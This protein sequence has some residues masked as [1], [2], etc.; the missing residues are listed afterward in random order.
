MKKVLEVILALILSLGLPAS[1]AAASPDHTQQVRLYGNT[2]YETAINIEDELAKRHNIDFSTGQKFEN[3]VLASGNNF[4]DALAGAPLAN[5]V[6]APILLVDSTPEASAVTLNYIQE[7]VKMSGNV[8]LLGGTGVIPNSFTQKLASMGFSVQNIQQLGGK[9]RN[10]TSLIISKQIKNS[11]KKVFLVSDSNFTDAL[12]IAPSAVAND[13]PIL[14]VADTGLTSDQKAFCDLQKTAFT[15][16][17]IEKNINSIYP[18]AV[19][20]YLGSNKYD[21]NGSWASFIGRDEAFICLATGEDYPDAL[22]GAVLAGSLGGGAIFLTRPDELPPETVKALN[23]TS[24]Y[25]K[26]VVTD[27]NSLGQTVSYPSIG[28]PTLFILGGSGAVSASVQAQAAAI[29]D[30]PGYSGK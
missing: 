4:P 18:K 8:Y 25:D 13:A 10:E 30:G 17:E 7:H 12:T 15:L 26:Q 9:D 1:V 20:G 21:T 2:R 22:A 28:Y 16:G 14:L 6:G 11:G 29:L 24:Y 3:V 27:T 23:I 19:K 5:Q